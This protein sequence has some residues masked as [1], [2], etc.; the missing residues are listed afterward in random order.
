MSNENMKVIAA[1]Y[2]IPY[3]MINAEMD[4]AKE[5]LDELTE[6]AKFYK[7]YKHGSDFIAEGT[8]GDYIPS[9][10]KYKMSASLINKEARF[11]FAETPDFVIETKG[12]LGKVT[13]ESKDAIT[14]MQDLVNTILTENRIEDM[15]I[16]AAKDCFIGKRVA[17]VVNFNEDTGVTITFL[18]ALNFLYETNMDDANE[19]SKFVAFVIVKDRKSLKDK[20]IL[21]KS[22]VMEDGVCYI[23]EKLY[24]GAGMQLE[25]ITEYQPTLLDR[26]PAAVFINDGLTSEGSGVSEIESLMEHEEYFSKMSNADMD[27]ERKSMNPIRYTIDMSPSSTTSLSS[28]PGSY[29]DLQTDPNQEKGTS[30]VGLL[31]CNLSYS[32]A[33]KVTLDRIKST[34]YELTEMPNIT[35]ESMTGVVTSGKALKS[36]Y[37]PLIVRCKEKM[38][39]WGPQLTYLI[40]VIIRGS[41]AYPN[42]VKRYTDD[43]VSPV[44]YEIKVVSN[45]PLPEDEAEEKNLDLSEVQAQTMSKKAYMMKWRGLTDQEAEDEL[46]QIAAEREMLEDSFQ[47]SQGGGGFETE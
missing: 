27:S 39:M 10:L 28:S 40:D 20:R 26:I 2:R 22:Y 1:N 41:M 5:F 9:K 11:L 7:V 47:G 31:E 30:K 21:K 37:W 8:S 17:G 33:L 32:D 14:V 23:E 44:A 38:K 18:S 35:L 24:D 36:I 3:A 6:I 34:A 15:L 25:V 42:C 29:W 46:S 12:D 45:Y 4:N 19:L 13:Q 43:T 16:K